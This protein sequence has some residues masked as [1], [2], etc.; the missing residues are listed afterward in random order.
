M[1]RLAVGVSGEGT[2]LDALRAA[3]L[4]IR[5]VFTD[6]PCNAIKRAE[7]WV[8]TI[9]IP[10]SDFGVPLNRRAMTQRIRDELENERIDA[11]ALAGFMTVFD[12]VMFERYGGLMLNIH[13]S[14]LPSFPG[15]HPVRDAL[16]RGVKVTGITVHEVDAG[17]DTGRIRAQIVVP[18]LRGDTEER[19]HTRLKLHEHAVYPHEIRK[20]LIEKFGTC[21]S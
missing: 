5:L 14:L 1:P 18:I 3:R 6:R 17:V 8:R 13:P 19:L 20:F 11:I 2:N 16:A 21:T 9:I 12:P 4:P 7:K 15:N 10:R